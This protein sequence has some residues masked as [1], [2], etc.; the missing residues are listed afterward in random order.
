M[1][2]PLALVSNLFS[3]AGFLRDKLATPDSELGS[4]GRQVKKSAQMF[5]DGL[6][7]NP[8]IATLPTVQRSYGDEVCRDYWEEGPNTGPTLTPPFS[9]GQCPVTYIVSYTIKNA[10]GTVS[11]VQTTSG[12]GPV[13]GIE[14]VQ[15][16]PAGGGFSGTFSVRIKFANASQTVHTQ[17]TYPGETVNGTITNVTRADGNPDTCGNPPPK[18]TPGV[19]PTYT[20]GSPVVITPSPLLPAIEIKVGPP[21]TTDD[22]GFDISVTVNNNPEFNLGVSLGSGGQGYV[23]PISISGEPIDENNPPE[24]IDP[25]NVDEG[26][27]PDPPE[28][29]KYVGAVVEFTQFPSNIGVIV[30]TPPNHI[31]PRTV[32]NFR[33]KLKADS[34]GSFLSDRYDIREDAFSRIIDVN[35]LQCIGWQLNT[36]IGFVANIRPI[37]RRE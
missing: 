34:V 17:G 29:F 30:G 8:D 28:G 35:G 12:T 33:L 25:R 10:D 2:D 37:L 13:S 22:G 11:P 7:A 6:R 27:L 31:F 15:V 4:L 1:P 32:G 18:F 26:D 23:P 14:V 3:P 9:G 24:G 19:G 36:E 21:E 16:G 5:C 20:W